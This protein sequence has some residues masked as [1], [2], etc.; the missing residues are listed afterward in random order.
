MK[1]ELG[2]FYGSPV[3]TRTVLGFFLSEVC[4]GP[5]LV[6]PKHSHEQAYFSFVW[7]GGYEEQCG[8]RRRDCESATAVFH[9]AAEV[10]EDRF[11][12]AGGHLLNLQLKPWLLESVKD[13]G[14]IPAEATHFD[15]GLVV[16]LGF[17][18]CGAMSLDNSGTADVIH[19]L[20]F[21]ILAELSNST[22]TPLRESP[23]WLDTV[24]E[25]LHARF[26]EPLSL[27][28]VSDC[29]GFHPIHVARTFRKRYRCSV[30][31]YL[32]RLRIG[33]SCRKLAE[34]D[35]CLAD[36][37]LR[38]G[39]Y[40]QSHLSKSFKHATGMSPAEFRFRFRSR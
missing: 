18:L 23:R 37:A 27:A 12:D 9:P 15:G 31:E 3:R 11:S 35:L 21:E 26:D 4:Y 16:E 8:R 17:R 38:A 28:V 22:S 32:R 5:N 40:D 33:F 14:P 2:R 20:A 39:F 6:L 25:I 13:F 36:I 19:D 7:R 29:V 30:R 34:D 24:I 1:L 10:H